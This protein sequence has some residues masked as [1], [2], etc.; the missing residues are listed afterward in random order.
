MIAT[1]RQNLMESYDDHNILMFLTTSMLGIVRKTLYK[2]KV[3]VAS[4]SYIFFP[5]PALV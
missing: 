3:I 2:Q 4:I 1:S 5:H